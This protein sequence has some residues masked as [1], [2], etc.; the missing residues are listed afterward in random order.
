MAPGVPQ[1]GWN[2]NAWSCSL[3]RHGR[4]MGLKSSS[5]WGMGTYTLPMPMACG[6]RQV[7]EGSYASW[8]PDG[9]RLAVANPL[10]APETY[11]LDDGGIRTIVPSSDER[12]TKIGP[13]SD[14]GVTRVARTVP[15]GARV[16]GTVST[17]GFRLGG[18]ERFRDPATSWTHDYL[19]TVAPDG[20]DRRVLVRRDEEGAL[21]AANPS[22]A[23]ALVPV[24]VM[25]EGTNA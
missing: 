14:E 11:F 7:G 23:Q 22:P 13:R 1:V 17:Y 24:L 8:S 15:S 20:S 10:G 21:V 16:P 19:W 6:Y 3:T 2:S 9:S 18:T 25:Q 5:P 4:R 12:V